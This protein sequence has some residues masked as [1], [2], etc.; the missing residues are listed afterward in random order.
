MPES[1]IL[2]AC[3]QYIFFFLFENDQDA[4]NKMQSDLLLDKNQ[5]KEGFHLLKEESDCVLTMTLTFKKIYHITRELY[6]YSL[7]IDSEHS[8]EKLAI[9]KNHISIYT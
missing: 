6:C 9:N 2:S 7:T 4:V 8:A 1:N 3:L 5:A